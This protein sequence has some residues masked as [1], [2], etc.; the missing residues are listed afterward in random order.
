LERLYF[1]E[2]FIHFSTAFLGLRR[3]GALPQH[4]K[5]PKAAAVVINQFKKAAKKLCKN[6][7]FYKQLSE[8]FYD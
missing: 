4:H 5:F 2:I 8:T 3:L 1:S 7:S 6:L